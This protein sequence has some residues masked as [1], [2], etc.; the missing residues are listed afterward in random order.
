MLR[1]S[2]RSPEGIRTLVS[3]GKIVR[4]GLLIP[5]ITLLQ[6]WSRCQLSQGLILPHTWSWST[7]R[8]CFQACFPPQTRAPYSFAVLL[9]RPKSTHLIPAG[10][11]GWARFAALLNLGGQP[12]ASACR[13][14]SW[15]CNSSERDHKSSGIMTQGALRRSSGTMPGH[16]V[17]LEGICSLVL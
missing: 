7:Y 2:E 14:M 13:C 9:R 16:G 17:H 3:W 4:G 15:S 12:R 5:Y 6:G 11:W 1:E 8:E 10:A